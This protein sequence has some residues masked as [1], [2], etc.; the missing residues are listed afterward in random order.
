MRTRRLPS[1]TGN[2]WER[3]H[4]SHVLK[5]FR[6]RVYETRA[7]T[8]SVLPALL[9]SL[10]GVDP[11]FPGREPGALPLDYRDELFNDS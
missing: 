10:D 11:S 9:V 7:S 3:G 8:Y 6:Q 1:L 2:E 5:G 4:A